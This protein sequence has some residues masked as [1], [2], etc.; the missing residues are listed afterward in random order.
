MRYLFT[1]LVLLLT[2]SCLTSEARFWGYEK[3]NFVDWVKTQNDKGRDTARSRWNSAKKKYWTEKRRDLA[4][5]KWNEEKKRFKSKW[6]EGKQQARDTWRETKKTS[7]NTYGDERGK[8][9]TFL[10]SFLALE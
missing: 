6:R 3:G 5:N 2:V 10:D 7:R 8:V 9:R 1:V 4:K